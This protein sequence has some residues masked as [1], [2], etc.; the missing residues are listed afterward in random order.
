MKSTTLFEAIGDI[1]DKKIADAVS[2]MPA[3]KG[4]GWMKITSLAAC[5]A[6]IAG[7]AI[8]GIMPKSERTPAFSEQGSIQT[9][10][11]KSA[12][13]KSSV[14]KMELFKVKKKLSAAKLGGELS[15]IKSIELH[16]D[17]EKLHVVVTSRKNEDIKKL[18]SYVAEENLIE[19]EYFE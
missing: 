19:I 2:P 14:G 11:V 9:E 6:L 8:Y 13:V 16:D 4:S 3:L 1:D 18:L 7:V 5:C 15:F 10:T 12:S 17:S